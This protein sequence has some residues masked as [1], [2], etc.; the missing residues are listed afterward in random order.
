MHPDIRRNLMDQK[1]FA[2]GAR[3]FILWGATLIDQAHRAGDKEADG[4]ISLMTPV[5][6]GFLTDQGY[7]MT[8]QAQQIY[9]GHG[10]IENGACRNIPAMPASR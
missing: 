10:Y 7:D 6:K 2:E 9:G 4:L 1:S 5:I 3:A 8:V